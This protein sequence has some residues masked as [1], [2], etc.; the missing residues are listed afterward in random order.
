MQLI[1]H[2][3]SRAEDEDTAEF[4][5]K[6]I[7]VDSAVELLRLVDQTAPLT[8][9]DKHRGSV[10]SS[11]QGAGH[12]E[13]KVKYVRT[14]LDV[15]IDFTPEKI[16]RL[17]S[18]KTIASYN[19]HNILENGIDG[20]NFGGLIGCTKDKVEGV[21]VYG[22]GFSRIDMKWKLPRSGLGALYIDFL[23]RMVP[24]VNDGPVLFNHLGK[25]FYFNRGEL[26]FCG[27]QW[28]DPGQGTENEL[29]LKFEVRYNETDIQVGEMRGFLPDTELRLVEEI[30]A[31]TTAGVLVGDTSD[32]S[33]PAT[34]FNVIIGDEVITVTSSTVIG[35]ST[36]WT[37]S[38]GV[39]PTVASSHWINSLIIIPGA[40]VPA[41]SAYGTLSKEGHHYMWI[42]TSEK[43]ER[44]GDGTG[45]VE[46]PESVLIEQV[47]G[48]EDFSELEVFDTINDQ[49]AV[50]E[51]DLDDWLDIEQAEGDLDLFGPPL[52]G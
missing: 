35:P 1:E 15:T 12:Y 46:R 22:P 32:I 48:Y 51:D 43:V 42:R 37:I 52:L 39:P 3:T 18:I 5:Y 20:P 24:C 23:T 14:F 36:V 11:A 13:V 40:A 8:Y 47:Y 16:K 49:V 41:S 2:V 9:H 6:A 27:G 26:L 44:F 34:P 19:V 25:K 50:A 31:S 7:E 30:D 33:L 17:K 21:D 10:H 38:R 45:K 29:N 4:F 28:H